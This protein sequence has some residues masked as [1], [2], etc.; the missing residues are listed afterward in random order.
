[1][2]IEF[3]GLPGAGKSTCARDLI[4]T[5]TGYVSARNANR[6]LSVQFIFLHPYTSFYWIVQMLRETIV[7]GTWKLMRFKMS[8]LLHTFAQTQF[9]VRTKERVILD[10]G[11]MQRV[12][13]VFETKKT[14]KDMVRILKHVVMPDVLIEV[15]G[16]ESTFGQ[17]RKSAV[18][19]GVLG[20]AYLVRWEE[21]ARH[22]YQML[23]RALQKIFAVHMKYNW[24]HDSVSDIHKRIEQ[25]D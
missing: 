3:I 25:Y 6:V 11:L 12:L 2:H 23:L 17:G 18:H 5:H 21:I 1:M 9:A 8:L 10:E 16:G 22:N 13:S 24:H 14:E 4:A 7:S 19:R 15:S 20:D